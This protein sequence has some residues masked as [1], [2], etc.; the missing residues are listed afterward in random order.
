MRPRACI[1]AIGSIRRS[2]IRI[3]SKTSRPVTK[4]MKLNAS[5]WALPRVLSIERALR[6]ATAAMPPSITAV[7][8]PFTPSSTGNL[9]QYATMQVLHHSV[10]AIVAVRLSNSRSRCSRTFCAKRGRARLNSKN[11]VSQIHS[12]LRS[13]PPWSSATTSGSTARPKNRRFDL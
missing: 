13:D 5:K 3:A 2:S 12:C 11:C 10:S 1:R 6:S 4:S 7:L 8:A 9:C